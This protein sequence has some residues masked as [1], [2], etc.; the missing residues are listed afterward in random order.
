[1]GREQAVVDAL[2]AGNSNSMDVYL[3]KDLPDRWHYKNNDRVT[4]VVVTA[5]P[6]YSVYSLFTGFHPNTGEHGY[7]NK[8][9]NMRASYYSNGS[10]SVLKETLADTDGGGSAASSK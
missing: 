2:R 10:L 3:K 8:F 5:K 6:G 4:E 9:E 7:D 1:M